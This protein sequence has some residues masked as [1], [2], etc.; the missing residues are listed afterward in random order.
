[1]VYVYGYVCYDPIKIGLN[2][3]LNT[4]M[5]WNHLHKHTA[6]DKTYDH[7]NHGY[8]LQALPALLVGGAHALCGDPPGA[9]NRRRAGQGHQRHARRL[10]LLAR[11]NLDQETAG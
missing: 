6:Y 5:K 11:G 3:L 4:N 2:D 8:P 7:R 1:M 9:E 10:R